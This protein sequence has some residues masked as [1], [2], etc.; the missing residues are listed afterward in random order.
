MSASYETG[1][2]TIPITPKT[3]D[4]ERR[5]ARALEQLTAEDPTI[6]V[7]IDRQSREVVLGGT[8]E[9]HL[10]IIVDRL[11]RE[12]N[13][14]ASVGRPQVAYREA[15]TRPA[16]GEM[17]YALHIGGR[18]QYAH[19]KLRLLGAPRGKDYVF[20][21]CISGNSIPVEFIESV[22]SGVKDCLSRGLIAGYPI[23][24]VQVE[25]YDGSYHDV[26]STNAA[27][28]TAGFLAARD[29]VQKAAPVL[30]EPVML[31]EVTVPEEHVD[32]VMGNIIGRRGLV[33]SRQNRDGTCVLLA[34]APLAELFGYATDLRERTAG[35]GAFKTRFYRYQPRRAAGGEDGD[36]ESMVGAPL[37]PV[38]NLRV[39]GVALPEPDDAK[40]DDPDDDRLSCR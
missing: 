10:E 28:K 3:P 4:D 38:P 33:D 2:L 20:R 15:L 29:A 13:V 8:G 36:R 37:K 18:G 30:L 21:N 1:L 35:R 6:R 40:D 24:G 12:F 17:K 22:E 26:D 5:L 25:L 14:E 7:Q 16:E 9:L 34:R 11:K 32:E 19:V 23:H 27:F 31:L 39:S